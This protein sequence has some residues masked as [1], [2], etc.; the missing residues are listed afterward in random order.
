MGAI[1]R[2]RDRIVTAAADLFHR[3]GFQATSLAKIQERADVRGGSLYYF[4]RSKEELLQAVLERYCD[5]L[6][7]TIID[8]AFV[9]SE[10]PIERVFLILDRY[11][12]TLL[13][14]D[15]A[16]GCPIGNL[17]IEMVDSGA[18]VRERLKGDFELWAQRIEGCLEAA[19]DR[20]PEE[21]DRTRLAGFV[22]AVM[23][24]AILLARGHGEIKP[25]D[26]AIAQLRDYFD[27]LTGAVEPRRRRPR[28]AK[29]MTSTTT[30]VPLVE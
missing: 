29:T 7:A 19:S 5:L 16:L 1:P 22:L 3:H 20:L 4:F 25:F 27:R 12:A 11:R 18:E 28:V 30:L 21:V 17:A 9:G 24:G 13:A 2:T 26:D 15:F 8:P 23:E 14:T 6:D 10:D